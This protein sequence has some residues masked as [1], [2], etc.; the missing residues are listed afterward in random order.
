MTDS[1]S[2]PA[3]H[4]SPLPQ[5]LPDWLAYCERL[6][7]KSIEMGLERVR[8]VMQRMNGGRGIV[9]PC[10]LITVAGTN[11]KGS[12][13]AMLE[14]IYRHAGYRTGLYTSPHLV[15]FEERAQV[16]GEPVEAAALA[17]A[18]AEVERARLGAGGQPEVSLTYF[19]FSTLAIVQTLVA[20][21][22]EVLVLEI[23]MGGRL[24]A[25]NLWD[26]DCA[27]ITSIDLDHME[28]LGPNREAI[29]IEIA[30]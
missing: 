1:L 6:H 4:T 28:F 23:G 16:R 22:P 10:P 2:S 19:E 12:T 8:T 26:A 7:P 21:Q 25:V 30:G 3:S 20:A 18:F 15:H 5:T 24:D 13:C 14:S 17:A 11:G 9:P 27:I 29:G